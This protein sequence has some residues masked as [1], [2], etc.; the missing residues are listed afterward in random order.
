MTD[1]LWWVWQV[2]VHALALLA[3]WMVAVDRSA[4]S[5]LEDQRYDS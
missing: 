4:A 2:S 3:V 1:I 5:D